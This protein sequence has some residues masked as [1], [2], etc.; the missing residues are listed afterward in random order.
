MR[1]VNSEQ[2]ILFPDSRLLFMLPILPP[3]LPAPEYYVSKV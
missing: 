3:Y 2:G 1:T